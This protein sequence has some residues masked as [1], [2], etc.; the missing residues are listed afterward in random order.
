MM[1]SKK[2]KT[3]P[4]LKQ[5]PIFQFEAI[6]TKW[7]INIFNLLDRKDTRKLLDLIKKRIETFDKNYS[8][9]RKDSLVWKIFQHKGNFELPSDSKEMMDLYKKLYDLTDQKFTPL[10][11]QLLSDTGYD[12]K[13]SFKEKKLIQLDKWE[14]VLK[15]NPPF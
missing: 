7:V 8:R 2:S 5:T 12:Y 6:G 3:K 4:D 10:I 9:F 15:Y 13:Y 14:D 1:P 11:G